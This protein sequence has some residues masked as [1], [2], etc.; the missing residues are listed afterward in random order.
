MVE[1][2]LPNGCTILVE[3]NEVG[4]RRYYTDEV[5]NGVLVW[6]TSLVGKETL[7]AAIRIEEQLSDRTTTN[8][9]TPLSN[10]T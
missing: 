1:H 5:G 2:Q 4:G 8:K 10:K 9:Q 6:D 3:D 7:L